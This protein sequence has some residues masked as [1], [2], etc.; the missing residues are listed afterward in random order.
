MIPRRKFLASTGL[1]TSTSLAGCGEDTADAE[2]RFASELDLAD[3]G[4]GVFRLNGSIYIWGAGRPRAEL[5]IEILDGGE[6][7]TSDT[8]TVKVG[9][10][11]NWYEW[12]YRYVFSESEL[13]DLSSPHAEVTVVNIG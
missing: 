13:N 1:L 12:D 5:V 7:I 10:Q 2:V 6:L 3:N 8:H 4:T 11:H 9:S